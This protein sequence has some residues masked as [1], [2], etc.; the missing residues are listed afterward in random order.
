MS[1][2]I[3]QCGTA[4]DEHGRQAVRAW[5]RA[6][7]H[8]WNPKGPRPHIDLRGA[9]DGAIHTTRPPLPRKRLKVNRLGGNASRKGP[10]RC[11]MP[12]PAPSRHRN[13]RRNHSKSDF[14][15]LNACLMAAANYCL[16]VFDRE[17]WIGI[18]GLAWPHRAL[19]DDQAGPPITAYAHTRTM[20]RAFTE[21]WVP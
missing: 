18:L 12:A 3:Q 17:L 2:P 9:I 8:G 7:R 16:Y 5:S 14:T 19:P 20:L 15:I 10:P 1:F 6:D 4:C 11:Y 13:T 21:A